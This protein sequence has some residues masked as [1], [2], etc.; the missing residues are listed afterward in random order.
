MIHQFKTSEGK[1]WITLR[2]SESANN[3]MISRKNK[4][5]TLQCCD[6]L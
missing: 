2:D 1:L 4:A 6:Y 5:F 3:G